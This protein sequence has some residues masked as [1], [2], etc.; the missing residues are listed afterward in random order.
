[1]RDADMTGAGAAGLAA[2][3][4][5]LLVAAL[6]LAGG[7]AAA[8]TAVQPLPSYKLEPSESSAYPYYDARIE[9]E[10][11]AAL[12]H[13]SYQAASE[14]AHELEDA[15]GALLDDPTEASLAAARGAWLKARVAYMETE[16]LRFYGGP[17]DGPGDAI[18]HIDPW[19]IDE[20]FV[21]GLVGDPRIAITRQTLRDP[22]GAH[23][24]GE[25]ATG[26]HVIEFLLWG[27]DKSP[28]HGRPAAD[29]LAGGDRHADRRRLYLATATKLLAEDIDSLADAWAPHKPDNYAAQFLKLDRREALGR[30]LTGMAVLADEEIARRRLLGALDARARASGLARY[31]LH[32]ND[33]LLADLDGIRAVWSG[34][35]RQSFGPGL[36][37]LVQSFDPKLAARVDRRLDS[38]QEALRRLDK[39]FDHAPRGSRAWKR[40]EEAAAAFHELARTLQD[41][42]KLLAVEVPLN[43][44]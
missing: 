37:G 24:P 25:A 19:P 16:P 39:P 36:D 18:A 21:E 12:A 31:S 23:G 14:A 10:R 40:V 3:G 44:G 4:R 32:T 22:P 41:V 38:A 43:T 42:G 2:R 7:P 30:M 35:D 27:R 8:D 11:Y 26:F 5:T 29:Y 6:L 34:D 15:V 28:G 33:D 20:R 13:E 9:I 1:M 17:I